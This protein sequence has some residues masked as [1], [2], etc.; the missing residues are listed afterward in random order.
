MS[1]KNRPATS[2]WVVA[3]LLFPQPQG[4]LIGWLSCFS[5]LCPSRTEVWAFP[6][7]VSGIVAQQVPFS[8]ATLPESQPDGPLVF[9]HQHEAEHGSTGVP[10]PTVPRSKGVPAPLN[11]CWKGLMAPF[12]LPARDGRRNR[13]SNEEDGTEI[14]HVIRT[15]RILMKKF[16]LEPPGR[17]KN[18]VPRVSLGNGGDDA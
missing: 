7:P 6:C 4:H 3:D 17:A 15:C 9:P 11:L 12:Q 18:S 14:G 16:R 1:A 5:H 2:Q 13:P 8:R 10:A